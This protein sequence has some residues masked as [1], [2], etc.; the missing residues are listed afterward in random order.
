MLF[1]LMLVCAAAMTLPPLP[2]SS[3]SLYPF[4]SEHA[5]TVHYLGHHAAYLNNLNN[6]VDSLRS[7]PETKHLAKQGIDWLL[8]HLDELPTEYRVIVANQGGGFVNHDFFWQSMRP[9]GTGPRSPLE[10]TMRELIKSFGSWEAAQAK[11]SL[12]A[13]RVFGSGWVWLCWDIRDASLEIRITSNQETPFSDVNVVP[14]L[15]LDIWEHS[16]YIDY[17]RD[18]NSYITRFW[19]VVDWARVESRLLDVLVSDEL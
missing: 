6:A 16:Y 17:E 1:T 13:S 2:Y 7:A 10:T 14:V 8:L 3:N 18:R 15:T 12:E 4:L 19:E 5:L 9:Y 11:F